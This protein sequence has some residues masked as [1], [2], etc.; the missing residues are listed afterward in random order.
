MENYRE[1]EQ[2]ESMKF[3]SK[4]KKFI[5]KYFLEGQKLDDA[6][7]KKLEDD[8]NL[9]FYERYRKYIA[10]LI[11]FIFWHSIWWS[12]AIRY[13]FFRLYPTRY[14]MA[15]TMIFGATVAGATSEGGGAVAFP[16][17][18]LLLHIDSIVARDFSLMIQSCGMTS[19]TFAILWMR[20]RVE[21]KCLI[22]TS[23][24]AMFSIIIGLQFFVDNILDSH[25]K[26]MLFVSIWSSFAIALFM[27]NREKKRK[28]F[29]EIQNFNWIKALV[30]FCT[31]LV[32]GLCSAFAGS[33]VD[34]CAFS[35]LT[36]L[37]RVSEKVA[38]PT[39]VILMAVNTVIGFYWRHAMM[40]EISQLAWEYF[41]VAIPVVVFFAP[42]GA[43]LSSHCH[44]QVLASFVYILEGLSL[45]GFL[46]TKPELK[47]ILIGCGII[48]CSFGFFVIIS[49]LGKRLHGLTKSKEIA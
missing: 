13:N 37:F 36:L 27:L 44:R 11:P 15:V 24:G 9:P 32:G 42:F 16:V 10:F 25:Q 7:M 38:T 34:I 26:K 47:L 46:I 4:L 5:K 20:V 23:L 33:G 6:L 49:R 17:M 31:G 45:I 8:S 48:A 35:I 1:P 22:F 19:A 3:K 2:P 43:F 21:W 29:L 40:N 41:E 12:L 14:E 39:T 28:T 30:L 18:T